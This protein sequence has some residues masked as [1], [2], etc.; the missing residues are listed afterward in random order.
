M[1]MLNLVRTDEM[2]QLGWLS[3]QCRKISEFQVQGNILSQNHGGEESVDI[4]L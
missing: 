1:T 2:V 4:C 3:S